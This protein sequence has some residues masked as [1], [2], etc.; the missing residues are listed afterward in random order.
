MRNDYSDIINMTY[1]FDRE[2]K[3]HPPMPIEDRA[4]IFGS[5][6]ALRGHDEEIEDRRE[7]VEDMVNNHEIEHTILYDDI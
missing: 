1:P 4:K 3:K 7:L 2:N 6:A 5:F